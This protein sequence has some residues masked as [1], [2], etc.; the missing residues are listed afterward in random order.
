MREGS[1]CGRFFR[2][3]DLYGPEFKLLLPDGNDQYYTA[4]GGAFCLFFTIIVLIYAQ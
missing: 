4:T 2:K 3:F 1:K